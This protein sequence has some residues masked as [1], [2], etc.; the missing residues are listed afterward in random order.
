MADAVVSAYLSPTGA[1][2]T[3]KAAAV[4]GEGYEAVQCGS[5][6]AVLGNLTFEDLQA[7]DPNP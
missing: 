3:W 5:C 2:Q 1:L 4:S 7:L 6:G